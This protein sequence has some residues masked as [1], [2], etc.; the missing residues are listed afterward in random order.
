MRAD[1]ERAAALDAGHPAWTALCRLLAGTAQHLLGDRKAAARELEDAARRAA[2]PAPALHALSLARLAL[3]AFEESDQ[4]AAAAHS[5][6]ARAQIDRHALGTYPAMALVLAVSAL[7]R[8]HRG[9]VEAARSDLDDAARLDAAMT[10]FA[11]WYQ[12][13]VRILLSRAAL[14]LGDVGL[15]RHHLSAAARRLRRL[16]DAVLLQ[17]ALAEA[18]AQL[19]AFTAADGV[20]P[21]ASMTAA[22]LRILR[23]LPTHLSFREI[24]ERTHVSANTVK[25]QANAIYRKLD[26]SS[27]SEAVACARRCGLLDA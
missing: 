2:V 12:A 25:S 9:R 17:D 6:R 21:P 14:R 10:D 24:A 4:E 19:L 1:A 15:A 16:P 5:A 7:V 20:A 23:F 18:Q 27:R 22:E 13:E 8:S 11:P 3:I 26:V